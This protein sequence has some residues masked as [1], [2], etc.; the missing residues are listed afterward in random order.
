M[1]VTRAINKLIE[2]YEFN[3]K[4]QL[5]NGTLL[6]CPALHIGPKAWTHS[7]YAPLEDK[8][9]DELELSLFIKIPNSYRNFLL[10]HNGIK[11]FN[12]ALSLDGH[13]QNYK[14]D[15][16]NIY[17]PY[18]LLI[19]NIYERIKDAPS[20]LFFIGG[21]SYDGSLLY[22]N[23]E[24]GS[25]HR[26]SQFTIET[27]NLWNSFEDMIIEETTRLSLLFDLKGKKIKP[28]IPT[29]P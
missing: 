11:I 1:E 16:D 8:L 20:N 21:Y 12:G 5:N 24:N 19:P 18:S 2:K 6:V 15:D 25:V 28:E 13:R 17:Q 10:I 3:G 4:K 9:I 22:I 29:T 26:C 7:F 27:L 14:R 23:I